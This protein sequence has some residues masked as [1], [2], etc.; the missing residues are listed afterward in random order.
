MMSEQLLESKVAIV[1]GAARGIGR[2]TALRLAGAGCRVVLSGRSGATLDAVAHEIQL[3][4]GEAASAPGD[5]C[6]ADVPQRLIEQA[7]S[8]FGSVDILVNSAGVAK[9]APFLE[10]D[11]GDWQRMLDLQLTAT[12]RC[13]QAAA[14]EMVAAKRSG[15]IVNLSSIAAAMAMYGTGT[16]AAAK[17]GVSSLTRVMAVDLARYGITVNAVA[18][19]PVATEQFRA[20]NDDNAYRRRGH[21]IPLNRVAEPAEVA[22]AIVFL[23]SP[24]ARYITGQL[25]VVD[26]GA[27]AVGCYSFET[28]KRQE[29][30]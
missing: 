10:I 29:V 23:C 4:G 1:T 28:Y 14:R 8:R 30:T 25:L 3:A 26:G 18:P 27:S 20:V 15:S 24:Q 6:E 19:G 11:L 22:D 16:Y 17:G 2:A 5:L 7:R 21:A 13:G 12:F 9:H